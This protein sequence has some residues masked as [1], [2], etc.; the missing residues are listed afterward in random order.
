MSHDFDNDHD[1]FSRLAT[2]GEADRE[3]AHEKG[4][5]N[6]DQAWI[7]SDRDAWYKNAFYQGPP[8]PHPEDG[9][10]E[11]DD[12]P[13]EDA[14]QEI[15]AELAPPLDEIPSDTYATDL[16]CER[17]LDAETGTNLTTHEQSR[18]KQ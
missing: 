6:P 5:Q 2:I 3:Y 18:P 11:D 9:P 10:Y 12:E 8:V 7:L 1:S 14:N 13:G 16:H 17:D 4:R 15:G